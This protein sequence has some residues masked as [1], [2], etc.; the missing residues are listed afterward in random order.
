MEKICKTCKIEKDINEFHFV[1]QQNKYSPKCKTC[2]NLYQNLVK[3]KINDDYKSSLEKVYIKDTSIKTFN[4]LQ[5]L[6]RYVIAKDLIVI[7]R[8]ENI[9]SFDNWDEVIA[10]F[11]EEYFK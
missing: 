3:K 9:V 5:A 1:K 6:H 2:Y 7:N 8:Y 11:D 4:T 10:T